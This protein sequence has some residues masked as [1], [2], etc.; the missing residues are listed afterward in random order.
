[1]LDALCDAGAEHNQQNVDGRTALHVAASR[2]QLDAVKTLVRRGAA[3]DLPDNED[4]TVIHT[5]LLAS[6]TTDT[7]DIV[8]AICNSDQAKADKSF[9]KRHGAQR[10]RLQQCVHV[11]CGNS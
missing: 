3:I 11:W 7:A 8:A 9:V 4:N 6:D 1:M 10:Y 5:A 2:G